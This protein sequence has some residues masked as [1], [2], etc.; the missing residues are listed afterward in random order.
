[1]QMWRAKGQVVLRTFAS[2]SHVTF[3]YYSY[4]DAA[5]F[6]PQSCELKQLHRLGLLHTT[7]LNSHKTSMVETLVSAATATGGAA[8]LERG[9]LL[10]I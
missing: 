2:N 7:F 5:N 4:T 8:Y 9:R 1:M 10:L 3:R 6:E